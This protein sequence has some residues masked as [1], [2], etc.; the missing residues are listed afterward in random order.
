M[1]WSL[2]LR[3]SA[4]LPINANSTIFK[5]I[6]DMMPVSTRVAWSWTKSFLGGSCNLAAAEGWFQMPYLYGIRPTTNVV[7]M[8]FSS[9]NR[10]YCPE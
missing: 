2:H 8:V 4:E 1:P 6:Y 7:S 10:S 3:R 9:I 5:D